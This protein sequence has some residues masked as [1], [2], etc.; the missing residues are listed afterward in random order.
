MKKLTSDISFLC[1]CP[2]IDH[3]FVKVAV[4]PQT[5]LTMFMTKFIVNNRTDALQTDIN[6]F[7]TITNCRIASSRSLKRRMNFFARAFKSEYCLKKYS[8]CDILTT[9]D[10][11]LWIKITSNTTVLDDL[12]LPR[13]T[14]HLRSKGHDY[15]LPRVRTSRFKSTF[16]NRCLF[17]IVHH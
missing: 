2:A 8:I 5:T 9:R 1:V 14:R 4:D 10:N 7:F 13:R 3:F 12:L 6:L 17:S 16:V 15:I 11:K